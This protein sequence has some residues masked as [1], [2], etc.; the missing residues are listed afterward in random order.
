[1]SSVLRPIGV[2]LWIGGI[3]VSLLVHFWTVILAV[4]Y[5]GLLAGVLAFFFPF[6][7]EIVVAIKVSR[8]AG[9]IIN[10]YLIAIIGSIAAY[11]IGVT[12]ASATDSREEKKEKADAG[13]S[14]YVCPRCGQSVLADPH[15]NLICGDCYRDGGETHQLEPLA[16]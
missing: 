16:P 12:I 4:G 13:K 2:L 8:D 10:P 14:E 6:I 7:S 3:A 9:S 5:A 15:A 11:W 1:M